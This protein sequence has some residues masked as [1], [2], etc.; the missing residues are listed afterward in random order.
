MLMNNAHVLN[1][2]KKINKY[3]KLDGKPIIETYQYLR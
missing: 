2:K 3:P 1:I